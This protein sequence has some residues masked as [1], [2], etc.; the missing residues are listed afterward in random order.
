MDITNII[1][2]NLNAHN[3]LG[4]GDRLVTEAAPELMTKAAETLVTYTLPAV[5]DNPK[6]GKKVWCETY[7]NDIAVGREE[8]TSVCL[9]PKSELPGTHQQVEMEDNKWKRVDHGCGACWYLDSNNR[10]VTYTCWDC[11]CLMALCYCVSC[12]VTV[13]TSRFIGI[14][15]FI[16]GRQTHTW[17]SG[18]L[19][20]PMTPCDVIC[21]YTKMNWNFKRGT[22]NVMIEYNDMVDSRRLQRCTDDNHSSL[23]HTS[24]V[25]YMLLRLCNYCAAGYTLSW[26]FCDTVL[27]NL[28][29]QEL[30]LR[31]GDFPVY[32]TMEVAVLVEDRVGV[33]FDV[34]LCVPWDAPEAVVDINSADVV[35]LGSVRP[36]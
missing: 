10:P 25:L 9:L 35:T 7:K 21:V 26:T 1:M 16:D 33:T 12:L 31:R 17:G 32:R 24:L 13:A 15:L 2:A 34:K 3:N 18:L 20:N 14:D 28:R 5:I 30:L 11:R 27:E 29:V 19:G 22:N 36:P 23:A 8:M 6:P 4:Y